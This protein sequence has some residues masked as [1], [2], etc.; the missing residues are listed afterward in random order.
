MAKILQFPTGKPDATAEASTAEVASVD[1]DTQVDGDIQAEPHG[2]EVEST[3][4]DVNELGDDFGDLDD[5][6]T[7]E[8]ELAIAGDASIEVASQQMAPE[9][10]VLPPPKCVL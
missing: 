1:G 5:V 4:S 9:E 2:V 3:D 6:V 10:T 7:I 8:P